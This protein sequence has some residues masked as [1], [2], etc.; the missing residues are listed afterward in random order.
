[1]TKILLLDVELD[2]SSQANQLEKNW[3][4]Y[5]IGILYLAAYIKKYLD[6][7]DVEIKIF[8]T[9]IYQNAFDELN[10]LLLTFQPDI[11]GIRALSK[12]KVE[13]NEYAK[14]L[15]EKCP[16]ALLIAGGPYPSTNYDEIIKDNMV[17]IVCIG[18][19]EATFLETVKEYICSR[20][21][22]ID[23]KGTAVKTGDVTTVNSSRE[24]IANIDT[25]PF[26]DYDMIN[27]NEYRGFSNHAFQDT[28]KCAYILCSRGCPFG[29]FY[30]HQ[31][32]GKKIRRRS[33][34]NI[35]DELVQKYYKYN[36]KE[37][38]IIDDV[39][40]IPL[41]ECKR[42]L[43]LIINE[44]PNDIRIN[45]PNGLRADAIDNELIFLFKKC[46]LTS[47]ALAVESASEKIQKLIGKKLD[48]E[49]AFDNIDNLSRQFITTVFYMIG[50]PSET[51]EDAEKTIE[52]ALK[53][54]FVSQPVLSVLRVYQNTPLCRLL[55]PTTEQLEFIRK[56][57]TLDLQ[58][59]INRPLCFYGDVF[60]DSVVPLNSNIINKLRMKWM[61]K[62][63]LDS[64]RLKNSQLILEMFLSK[65]EIETFYKD[66]FDNQN[67]DM[68]TIK[69]RIR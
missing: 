48:V 23:I 27:I 11:I 53:L 26:P 45:F 2:K 9:A 60:S 30:C 40:N 28:S 68:D 3:A 50:F 44:L 54:K 58:T 56:Q 5:P 4:H 16:E 6:V 67:F 25:I 69:K 19:G 17:D 46:G 39:F 59:K 13:F 32:F 34:E 42:V 49:K 31:L 33:P 66:L 65:E 64:E 61:K 7:D 24:L 15:N 37:F 10:R 14:L 29:C 8:H 22:P 57:E 1:V 43:R 20:K 51:E 12:Y 41:D 47:I 38:V 52:F 36:I 55:A 18:E 63:L 62:V 21:I 35:V